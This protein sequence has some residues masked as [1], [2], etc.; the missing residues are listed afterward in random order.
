MP[1]NAAG[2]YIAARN[3]ARQ[4]VGNSD[5][6]ALD[7]D[8]WV[9]WHYNSICHHSDYKRCLCTVRTRKRDGHLICKACRMDRTEALQLEG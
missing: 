5:K 7:A 1:R 8:E 9:D 4:A 3:M 2:G 6:Y